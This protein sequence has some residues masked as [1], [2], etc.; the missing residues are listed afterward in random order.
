MSGTTLHPSLEVGGNERT[1][2]RAKLGRRKMLG[3]FYVE[4][5]FW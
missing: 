3:A 4:G 1:L 2:W 5:Y